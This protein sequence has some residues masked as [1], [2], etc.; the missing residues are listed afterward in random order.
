M[1]L[2]FSIF[3][4]IIAIT[5]SHLPETNN[6]NDQMLSSDQSYKTNQGF[7]QTTPIAFSSFYR[8][9]NDRV[10]KAEAKVKKLYEE[11]QNFI[12]VTEVLKEN[13]NSMAMI[14]G[15]YAKKTL[16]PLPSGYNE[17][18]CYFFW[19]SHLKWAT[20]FTARSG[21]T[22]KAEPSYQSG[23]YR[24]GGTYQVTC[25]KPAIP[26]TYVLPTKELFSNTETVSTH[27]PPSTP[28]KVAQ[29]IPTQYA[30]AGNLFAFVIPK[31][32]FS[33][34]NG[35]DLTLQVTLSD[36]RPL[37]VWLIF[38]PGTRKLLGW[39]AVGH[40]P[41]KVTAFDGY[42]RQASNEF[43]LIVSNSLWYY[44]SIIMVGAAG[45]GICAL[46]YL[47]FPWA[48]RDSAKDLRDQDLCNLSNDMRKEIQA[49]A[50]R[51]AKLE[52][53]SPQKQEEILGND[54][55]D[56]SKKAPKIFSNIKKSLKKKSYSKD[57]IMNNDYKNS[58]SDW[59][60]F[61]EGD[62]WSKSTAKGA[63]ALH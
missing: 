14:T 47:K 35:N 26:P 1:K 57:K 46:L 23:G 55:S 7:V 37:P 43:A 36:E 19:Y 30:A 25:I 16:L 8:D 31:A 54:Q 40:F 29:S 17:S 62:P 38:I 52:N 12:K 22:R 44:V 6:C 51:I 21:N 58:D 49:L 39:P 18:E 59:S 41:I 15:S 13:A 60:D 5:S 10:S 32:T 56:H 34:A 50:N 9:M 28:P 24:V 48:R 45:M 61:S 63:A 27:E 33:E 2:I 53:I 20:G 11:Y 4:A 3:T 42:G